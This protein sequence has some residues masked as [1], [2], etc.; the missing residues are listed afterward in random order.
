MKKIAGVIAIGILVVGIGLYIEKGANGPSTDTFT[1]GSVLPSTGDFG[2]LGEEVTRGALL[3]VEEAQARGV[4]V[5]YIPEDDAF[6]PT[7]SVRAASKLVSTDKVDAVF[8]VLGEEAK[9]ITPIFQSAKVPLLVAWDSNEYLKHAGNYI[10]SIGFSTEKDGALMADY[11]YNKLGLRTIAIAETIDP[12][13]LVLGDS[14]QQKFEQD[15]G[16]VLMREKEQYS[17]TDH[18]TTIAKINQSKADGV[19]LIMV[20]PQNI[21]FLPQLKRAGYTKPILSADTLISSDIEGAGVAAEGVYFANTYATN[22]DELKKKYKERFGTDTNETTL[23]SF[24]YDSIT[25][26][27]AAHDIAQKENIPLR[28]ALSKV[29]VQGLGTAIDLGGT[30]SSERIEKI[31]RIQNGKPV[32][33]MP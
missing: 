27:L 12:L 16:V 8:T 14:F 3:A 24:G 31:Y 21:S 20:P 25:T 10:F 19:Y 32:E 11:A 1:I 7:Q 4:M 22:P 5:N 26:L 6:D 23:V 28:D 13:A 9:P 30:Q 29:K 2:F 17:Q 15:G 33:V 18:R